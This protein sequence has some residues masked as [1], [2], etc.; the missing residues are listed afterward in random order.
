MLTRI[1]IGR[2]A[3]RH[4]LRVSLSPAAFTDGVGSGAHQHFS[5]ATSEG[6]CSREAP[7]CAG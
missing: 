1:I 6:R 5:L 7:A 2:V 4:G 3:R